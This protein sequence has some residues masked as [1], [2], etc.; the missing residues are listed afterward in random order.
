MHT[1]VF[2]AY[3][4]L[5]QQIFR[6]LNVYTISQLTWQTVLAHFF[7]V[8]LC[9]RLKSLSAFLH[10]VPRV[11]ARPVLHEPYRVQQTR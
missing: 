11:L 5:L 9:T 6:D 2:Y 4:F 1:T 3:C 7:N 10:T 8:R